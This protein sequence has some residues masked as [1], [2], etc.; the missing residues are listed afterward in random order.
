MIYFSISSPVEEYI[1]V[2]LESYVPSTTGDEFDNRSRFLFAFAENEAAGMIRMTT[3]LHGPL[4]LWAVEKSPLPSGDDVVQ[5]TRAVVSTRFRR[6]GLFTRMMLSAVEYA[7]ANGIRLASVAIE[8][9]SYIRNVL[10]DIGFVALKEMTLYSYAPERASYLVNLVCDLGSCRP[11]IRDMRCRLASRTGKIA[12]RCDLQPMPLVICVR[13]FTAVLGPVTL[14]G[15]L[16]L[17]DPFQESFIDGTLSFED[18]FK[19]NIRVYADPAPFC[20]QMLDLTVC[21]R[22]DV[23]AKEFAGSAQPAKGQGLSTEPKLW[24]RIIALN[25]L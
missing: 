5:L 16:C 6:I 12:N 20:V 19:T 23:L 1:S 25:D 11:R 13:Q 7:A 14:K 21:I 17:V 10:E 3:G 15:T 24:Q 4:Q 18:L 2:L 22:F 8:P 9:K